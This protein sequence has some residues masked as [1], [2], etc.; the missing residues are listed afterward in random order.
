MWEDEGERGVDG[1]GQD[2]GQ[3]GVD[4]CGMKGR[5]GLMDVG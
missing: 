4:G 2:E 5:E 3:R 1:C